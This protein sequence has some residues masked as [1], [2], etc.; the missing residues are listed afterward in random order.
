MGGGVRPAGRR[1]PRALDLLTLVAWCGAEPVPLALLT[2]H[3]DALPERLAA[4]VGDPL[5]LVRCTTVLRRRAMATVSPHSILLHRVPAALLRAR[6]RPAPARW[7]AAVVR[8]LRAA[9]PEDVWDYPAVWPRW[10]LLLTHILAATNVTRPLDDGLDDV[11]WLLH[12]AAAY[13]QTRG[14]PRAALPLF[15]RAYDSY[16]A[17]LGDDHPKTL[18]AAAGLGFDLHTL[19]EYGQARTLDADTLARSRRVLGDDHL[20]TLDAA[21]NFALDLRALGDL[22][23]AR[24]LDEDTLTR[25]RRILGEDHPWTLTSASNLA[26]DLRAL[27][28]HEEARTLVE[29]ILTRRR[30][31]LGDDHPH[32]LL[33]TR[34]LFADMRALGEHEEARILAEDTLTRSRRVL[35]DDHPDTLWSASNLVL[36]L[37]ALGEHEQADAL[38]QE[39][40]TWRARADPGPDA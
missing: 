28:R 37:R 17:Q 30:R 26:G 27:G 16:R 33:M 2:E 19:G 12:R 13:L 11:A 8:L 5:A 38:E 18:T 29:D 34:Y 10:R 36:D 1:R 4:T 14:E 35:G 39:I 6:T 21:L 25:S 22:E 40:S 23:E 32:T 31:I 3:V 15:R 24:T 7:P 20:D 9:A